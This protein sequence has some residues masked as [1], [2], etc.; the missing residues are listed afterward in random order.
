VKN[1]KRAQTA[2]VAP[3][4]TEIT[5]LVRSEAAQADRHKL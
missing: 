4:I 2:Y 5:R 3:L 1:G